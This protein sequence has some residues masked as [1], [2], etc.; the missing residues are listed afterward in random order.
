M[1]R[2][3]QYSA[4]Y[5]FF[6]ILP[7]STFRVNSTQC[8][9]NTRSFLG[10][11]RPFQHRAVRTRRQRKSSFS[12]GVLIKRKPSRRPSTCG[13]TYEITGNPLERPSNGVALGARELNCRSTD[14][15]KTR[16]SRS[17]QI[18]L[19]RLRPIDRYRRKHRVTLY[20][21]IQSKIKK[22]GL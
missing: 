11:P 21:L 18:F 3:L 12:A 14:V 4:T 8:R 22:K 2:A 9:R 17:L 10:K 5:F 7:P 6:L 1:N 15:R 20:T 13:P 16:M 19:L